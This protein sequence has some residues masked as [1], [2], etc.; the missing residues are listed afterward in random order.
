[1][2]SR[3]P[4]YPASEI[5]ALTLNIRHGTSEDDAPALAR[6]A[7]LIRALGVDL[8]LLQEV[9]RNTRRSGGVDQLEWLRADTGL[10]HLAFGANLDYEGGL[11]GNAVLSR[12]PIVHSTNHTLPLPASVREPRGLLHVEIGQPDLLR[13]VLVT[14]F[15]LQSDE[16]MAAAGYVLAMI[17]NLTGPVLLGGDL[18]AG[19]RETNRHEYEIT[20]F[21]SDAALALL[22][23]RLPDSTVASAYG[24]SYPAS[25]PSGQL[26]FL[27]FRPG[28]RTRD[29]A[30]AQLEVI[31]APIV[32]DHR[33]VLA[34]LRA[35][36]R[37]DK[38]DSASR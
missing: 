35:A 25:T 28:Q 10:I 32:S 12:F 16:R 29:A 37:A 34:I 7:A 15:P 1:M 24:G 30:L 8:V 17:E 27:L 2:E 6:Q 4:R 21:E 26:D 5:R 33:A 20:S 23:A 31:E 36:P 22:R 13:H 19:M 3:A 18:N 38:G 9:D 11:Y 14:H